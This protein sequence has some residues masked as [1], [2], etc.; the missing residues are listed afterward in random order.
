MVQGISEIRLRFIDD[1]KKSLEKDKEIL[2]SDLD[3][4]VLS[5]ENYFLR[6]CNIKCKEGKR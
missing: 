4:N 3:L 5:W 1:V 2:R 6:R